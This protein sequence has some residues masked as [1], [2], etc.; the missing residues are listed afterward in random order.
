M[1]DLINR[2]FLNF[3]YEENGHFN[4]SCCQGVSPGI[5]LFIQKVTNAYVR[6]MNIKVIN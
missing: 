3:Y 4:L 5:F 1:C 6:F 2:I